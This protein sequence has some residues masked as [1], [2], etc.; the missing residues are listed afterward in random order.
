MRLFLLGTGYVGLSI[1]QGWQRSGDLFWGSTTSLERLPLLENTIDK[2]FLLTGSDA[3]TMHEILDECDGA[4]ITVAPG[5]HAGY[6]ETYLHTAQSV[7]ASVKERKR[8]FYLLYTGST[9]VYGHHQ[10]RWV[11]EESPRLTATENGQILCATEDAYLACSNEWIDVCILR[12]AG[13]YGPAR[14]LE[15]RARAMSGRVN[16]GSGDAPT[17]HIHCH[18]IVRAIEFC[19][20]NR[21]KGI[22]NLCNDEHRTRKDLY[23]SI[24]FEL[25]LP[26]PLW[27]PS[28]TNNHI[29]DC[30]V[31]NKKLCKA[32]FHFQEKRG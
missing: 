20:N 26:P 28:K 22:Y 17:N 3:E 15:N 23:T 32:G 10:G 14:T 1:A 18:D 5:V 11:D 25:G 13:I 12:L 4:I 2:A 21:C 27:D 7:A 24:C 16:T 19:V 9:S 31:S 6:E 8:P 29:S 30:K